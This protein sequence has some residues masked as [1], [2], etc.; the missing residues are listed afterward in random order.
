[1]RIIAWKLAMTARLNERLRGALD[2][3]DRHCLAF[4]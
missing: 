4:G 3:R 1:L 2:R